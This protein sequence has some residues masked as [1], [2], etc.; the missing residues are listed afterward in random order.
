[1]KIIKPKVYKPKSI[2]I[3]K[4]KPLHVSLPTGRKFT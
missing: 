4:I 2:K 3:S 1:M